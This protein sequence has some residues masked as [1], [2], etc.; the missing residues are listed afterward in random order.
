MFSYIITLD[1]KE[2][3][4]SF[5]VNIASTGSLLGSSLKRSL[6]DHG[7]KK[8]NEQTPGSWSEYTLKS[9]DEDVTRR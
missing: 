7:S 8:V 3:G 9:G 1:R 2:P 4:H 5:I 6:A